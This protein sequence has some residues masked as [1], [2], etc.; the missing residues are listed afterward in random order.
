MVVVV[1]AAVVAQQLAAVA[2]AFVGRQNFDCSR[3]C[4]RFMVSFDFLYFFVCLFCS[5]KKYRKK[6][7]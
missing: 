3:H 6:N 4:K 1:V 2:V 7:E 5:K